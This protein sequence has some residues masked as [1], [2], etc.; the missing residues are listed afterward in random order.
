MTSLAS[1]RFN[2]TAEG[3]L[4]WWAPVLAPASVRLVD[5]LGTLE[6][7][8][9][10]GEGLDV[11]DVGCGTGSSLLEAARKWPG[12]R[13]IGLDASTGM[14]AVAERQAEQ[15]PAAARGRISFVESDAGSLPI[16]DASIDLVIT[17][18]MLQQ[19]PSRPAV[20]AEFRR[21]LRPGGIAAIVGWLTESESFAPEV[22]MEAALSDAGVVRPPNPEVRSGHYLS[23]TE[24]EEELGAAGFGAVSRQEEKLDHPWTREDFATYR[25][26]TR[27][28]DLFATL[29]ATARERM[30]AALGARLRMLTDD[31]LVYRP[32]IVTLVG[33]RG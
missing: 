22:E 19:V 32:P 3:Y 26:T 21:V 5:R 13:L 24:A 8:F 31:Q 16:A 11:L 27:D 18:F 12:A 4:R 17:A 7:G 14:L 33:R 20:L 6:P 2:R 29:D 23:A 25:E 30:L 10:G 1:E 9:P 15:L 28:F